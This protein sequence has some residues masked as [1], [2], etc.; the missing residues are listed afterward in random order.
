LT[1]TLSEIR[2]GFQGEGAGAGELTWGQMGIWRAT[3]RNDRTI[4]LAFP[5]PPPEGASVADVAGMLGFMVGRHPA[6]R[7]RLRFTAGPSGDRHPRQVI[8][9]S[10]EVPLHIV[11]IGDDDDV[12]TAA[13]ELRLRYEHTWFDY[14]NEFPV[15][16]GVI[17][18]RGVP[19]QLVFCYSH[20]MVDGS[21][22]D[23]IHQDLAH[24]DPTIPAARR[25][26]TQVLG[27]S[28]EPAARLATAG[29]RS[30]ARTTIC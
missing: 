21:G 25:A 5:M 23:L 17:R 9:A 16:M 19:V 22:L 18:R 28:T 7:T 15:R 27:G 29:A 10:G 30:S 4:N 20:V 6:L 2:V 12:A 14:E 3:L 26:S 13:E 11:D 1:I 24:L 8:A